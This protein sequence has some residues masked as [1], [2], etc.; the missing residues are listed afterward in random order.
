LRHVRA[1]ERKGP[2]KIYRNPSTQRAQKD[3]ARNIAASS[4]GVTDANTRV[5]EASQVSREIAKDIVGVDHA[6]EEMANGSDRVRSSAE[7][8]STV[9]ETNMMPNFSFFSAPSNAAAETRPA[10]P[11]GYRIIVT[12]GGASVAAPFPRFACFL[13]IMTACIRPACNVFAWNAPPMGFPL[14]A[15]GSIWPF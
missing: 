15:T 10:N 13:S 11:I 7:E 2:L 14:H 5:S 4:I 12:D 9:A 8:L 6:A 1:R 3:I